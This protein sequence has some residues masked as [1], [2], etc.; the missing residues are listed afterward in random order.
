V[1]DVC[2]IFFSL[3]ACPRGS[4]EVRGAFAL[5]QMK[6]S[7]VRIEKSKRFRSFESNGQVP[8]GSEVSARDLPKVLSSALL[9]YVVRR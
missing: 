8:K 1:V 3:L 6:L 7:V 5:M 4:L 9:T 2:L